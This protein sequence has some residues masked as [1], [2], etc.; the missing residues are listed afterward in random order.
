MRSNHQPLRNFFIL[1]FVACLLF[2]SV[3]L[4]AEE[5]PQS[6]MEKVKYALATRSIGPE[7]MPHTF[8]P[9]YLG[10]F[11]EEGIEVEVQRAEGSTLGLQLLVSGRLD[12][13][14]ANAMSLLSA[15]PK[16]F[17]VKSIYNRTRTHDS[18]LVT[19]ADSAITEVKQLKGKNLGVSSMA[20]GQMG[21]ARAILK[22]NGLDPDKD[23]SII[24]VGVGAAAAKSLFDDKI[25]ALVLWDSQYALMENLGYKFKYFTA[26]FQKDIF[27]MSLTTTDD[28]I[29]N[30]RELLVGFCRAVAKGT[31][32]AKTNPS[33]V[34]EI[35]KKIFPNLKPAD[36]SDEE[37]TRRCLHSL[38]KWLSTSANI[39]EWDIKQWGV[40]T[41]DQWTRFQNFFYEQGLLE[42]KIP[43][44]EFFLNDPSF[45]EEINSF[46]WEAVMQQA[47]NYK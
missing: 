6:Y 46:D 38:N 29:Q 11:L 35:Y 20:T 18:A 19:P 25:Q 31:L 43:V 21:F 37:Y 22:F 17:P 5:E 9:I 24:P 16:G 34:V 1:T 3:P 15:R 8:L 33:A 10:Y 14:G 44:E 47:K 23:V 32:F 26:P 36:L 13:I 30:N 39:E 4:F 2:S 28:N 40:N 42:K 41:I 45:Y 7:N 27:G 12:V